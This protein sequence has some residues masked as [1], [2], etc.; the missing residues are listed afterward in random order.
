MRTEAAPVTGEGSSALAAQPMCVRRC[1]RA[2]VYVRARV[3]AR[4][5]PTFLRR[6]PVH[7]RDVVGDDRVLLSDARRCRVV[8]EDLRVADKHSARSTVRKRQIAVRG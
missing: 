2:C 4:G 3:R 6:V 5:A 7:F 1:A 8:G